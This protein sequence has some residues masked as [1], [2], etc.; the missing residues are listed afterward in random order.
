MP[1]DVS[2]LRLA[3]GAYDPL[4]CRITE[5]LKGVSPG[6]VDALSGYAPPTGLGV[7]LTPDETT[8]LGTKT[9][10]PAF[11]GLDASNLDVGLSLA[12]KRPGEAAAI[13]QRMVLGAAT[14]AANIA[15]LQAFVT[16]L[17]AEQEKASKCSQ[18]SLLLTQQL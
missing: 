7:A 18:W 15:K 12:S 10:I 1:Q 17:D 16:L 13:R 4:L 3:S 6:H 5:T 2:T 11:D 9:N 14:S 8:L